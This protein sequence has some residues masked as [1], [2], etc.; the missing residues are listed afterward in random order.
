M[1]EQTNQQVSREI[2]S[3]RVLLA[4]AR[5]A[6]GHALDLNPSDA[7]VDRLAEANAAVRQALRNLR[8]VADQVSFECSHPGRINSYVYV[9]PD[10]EVSG[11]KALGMV[12]RDGVFAIQE[13]DLT[14]PNAF[15]WHEADPEDWRLEV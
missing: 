5:N 7:Q 3:D 2:E 6:C 14:S 1:A 13:N 12:N 15:G 8:L 11:K 4:S 9:G 10:P